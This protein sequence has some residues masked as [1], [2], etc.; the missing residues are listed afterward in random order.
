MLAASTFNRNPIEKI[1]PRDRVMKRGRSEMS[2]S[3]SKI[4]TQG[5]SFIHGIASNQ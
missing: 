3:G 2:Q 1:Q 4:I 5:V